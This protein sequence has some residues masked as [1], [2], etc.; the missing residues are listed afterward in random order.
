MGLWRCWCHSVARFTFGTVTSIVSHHPWS[1]GWPKGS[2]ILSRDARRPRLNSRASQFT[3][4]AG[5]FNWHPNMSVYGTKLF[6]SRSHKQVKT[7]AWQRKNYW[8]RRHFPNGVP[9]APSNKLCSPKQVKPFF[10]NISPSRLFFWKL[11]FFLVLSGSFFFYWSV[12]GL[13]F[14]ESMLKVS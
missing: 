3:W 4:N 13:P 14:Q 12:L 8:P 10:Y 9:H 6:Y 2:L 11:I 7:N 1:M 5:V